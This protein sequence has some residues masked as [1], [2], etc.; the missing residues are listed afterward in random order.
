MKSKTFEY[1]T[2]SKYLILLFIRVDNSDKKRKNWMEMM[3]K[4]KQS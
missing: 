2:I 4:T 1:L 3:S